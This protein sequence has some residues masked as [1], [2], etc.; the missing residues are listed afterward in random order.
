MDI[1]PCAY[2]RKFTWNLFTTV[3]TNQFTSYSDVYQKY[4]VI[5]IR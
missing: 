4:T 2:P 3:Y 1:N 5:N